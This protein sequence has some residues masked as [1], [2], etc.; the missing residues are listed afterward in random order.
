M[1]SL[2]QGFSPPKRQTTDTM[3][4]RCKGRRAGRITVYPLYITTVDEGIE[5]LTVLL[6]SGQ[7][8]AEQD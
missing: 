4:G 2:D 6:Q 7:A 8:R 1:F 3:P 5:L